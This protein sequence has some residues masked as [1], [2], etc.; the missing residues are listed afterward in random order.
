MN[1]P[2]PRGR[3]IAALREAATDR[4]AEERK[5]A[6]WLIVRELFTRTDAAARKAAC[7]TREKMEAEGTPATPHPPDSRIAFCKVHDAG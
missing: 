2:P 6:N 3:K 1:A 4:E 5:L 7:V